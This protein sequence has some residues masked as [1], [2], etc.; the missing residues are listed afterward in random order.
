MTQDNG[1]PREMITPLL[2]ESLEKQGYRLI[3]SHSGVKLCRW[4]K[5]QSQE[6]FC[7]SSPPFKS[8][9]K[10]HRDV[11]VNRCIT[12]WFLYTKQQF[13]IVFDF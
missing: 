13:I 10:F 7:G 8:V 1:E 11:V 2:R 4:T 5:V 12:S 6:I 3:G 9:V